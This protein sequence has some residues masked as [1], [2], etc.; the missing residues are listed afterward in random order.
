MQEL[1]LDLIEHPCMLSLWREVP[2]WAGWK[3]LSERGFSKAPLLCHQLTRGVCNNIGDVL[4]KVRGSGVKV[5]FW[6][7]FLAGKSSILCE[8]HRVHGLGIRLGRI[9]LIIIKGKSSRLNE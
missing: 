7:P 3:S 5:R 6:T 4:V 8:V 1:K 2:R 9:A